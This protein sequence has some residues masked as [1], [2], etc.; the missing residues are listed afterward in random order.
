MLE[1]NAFD[2]AIGDVDKDGVVE[3]VT[4]GYQNTTSPEIGL[5][6]QLCIWNITES[7]FVLEQSMEWASG[8]PT[9]WHGVSIVDVDNDDK[10]EIIAAGYTNDTRLNQYDA[11][12]TIFSWNGSVLEWEKVIFGTPS[13]ELTLTR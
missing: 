10:I 2:V 8:V 12:L 3:I 7:N 4:A 9:E 5:K 6:G 11:M 1:S 13:A